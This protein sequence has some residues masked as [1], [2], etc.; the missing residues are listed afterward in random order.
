MNNRFRTG[1]GA[2]GHSAVEI[3]ASGLLQAPPCGPEGHQ[4]KA[5][6]LGCGLLSFAGI[7]H[8]TAA[9]FML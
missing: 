5:R 9:A 8:V 7:P 2:A 4:S 6:N 3:E 1:S